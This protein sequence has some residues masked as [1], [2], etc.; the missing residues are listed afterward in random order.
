MNSSRSAFATFSFKSPFFL[1]YHHNS[2]HKQHQSTH[3]G[4]D[5]GDR[6]DGDGDDDKS[7]NGGDGDGED[8]LKCKVYTKV[9]IPFCQTK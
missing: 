8:S 5:D 7:N 6:G 2:Q 9:D 3:D 1:K 4:D